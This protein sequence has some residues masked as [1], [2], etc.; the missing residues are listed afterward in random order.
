MEAHGSQNKARVQI[1]P[2]NGVERAG[3]F[4]PKSPKPNPHIYLTSQA[5][6]PPISPETQFPTYTEALGSEPGKI[7][8][9]FAGSA[10]PF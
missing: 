6:A 1:D 2:Y 3:Q 8:L 10:G 4:K 7:G 5:H 9:E